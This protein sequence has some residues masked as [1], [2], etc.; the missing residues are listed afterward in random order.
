MRHYQGA[1]RAGLLRGGEQETGQEPRAV[2]PQAVPSLTKC[3]PT[4]PERRRL[5]RVLV[6]GSIGRPQYGKGTN[7]GEGLSKDSCQQ[8]DTGLE[9]LL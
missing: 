6:M 4:V 1:P 9:T 8:Q 5:S 7:R 2:P 3:R